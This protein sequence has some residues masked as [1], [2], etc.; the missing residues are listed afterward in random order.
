LIY[1]FGFLMLLLKWLR[2][3]HSSFYPPAQTAT[4]FCIPC[5]QKAK[6]G[7]P[8]AER[9][10]HCRICDTCVFK[11]QKHCFWLGRCVGQHNL[12]F[13]FGFLVYA[14]G[15]ANFT[16]FM[17][18]DY[19]L[20][21]LFSSNLLK[22]KL[23]NPGSF[24]EEVSLCACTLLTGLYMG[25][26][27]WQLV[28]EQFDAIAENQ[29]CVDALKDQFGAQREIWDNLKLFIGEDVL[30]WLLPTTP[31]IEPNFQEKVWSRKQVITQYRTNQFA[32]D[33]A[34]RSTVSK[35]EARKYS[36]REALFAFLLLCAAVLWL[37]RFQSYLLEDYD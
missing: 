17:M 33:P 10:H 35:D 27:L 12:K 2:A 8:K 26:M 21:L 14:C 5:S 3:R 32:Q 11:M 9:T 24:A 23:K 34:L 15:V 1:N 13:Y 36:R 18:A 19:I 16:A 4:E 37:G 28:L 31:V 25:S 22:D 20:C 7:V 30:W 6:R 29:S